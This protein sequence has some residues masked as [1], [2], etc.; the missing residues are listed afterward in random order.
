MKEHD[1][2]LKKY[3]EIIAQNKFSNDA[4][5]EKVSLIRNGEVLTAILCGEIPYEEITLDYLYNYNDGYA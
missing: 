4:S 1:P 2:R 3:F 5:K